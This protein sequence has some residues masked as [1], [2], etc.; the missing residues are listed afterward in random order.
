[1]RWIDKFRIGVDASVRRRELRNG[2]VAATVDV[3]RSGQRTVSVPVISILWLTIFSIECDD[4]VLQR[5]RPTM[6]DAAAIVAGT[7]GSNVVKNDRTVL[8]NKIASRNEKDTAATGIATCSGRFI[9]RKEAIANDGRI[10][11]GHRLTNA[12]STT[13]NT[14]QVVCK[15]AI[16]HGPAEV[17]VPGDTQSPSSSSRYITPENAIGD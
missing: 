8:H 14:A 12:Q 10:W 16:D 2:A 11:I 15:N 7:G 1:M 6:V 5:S 13:L 17:C 9:K 3:V 4:A